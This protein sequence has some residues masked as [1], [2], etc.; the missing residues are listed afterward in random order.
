MRYERDNTRWNLS[1]FPMTL[2]RG[3]WSK[4]FILLSARV[5]ARSTWRSAGLNV[6]LPFH[7]RSIMPM[8]ASLFPICGNAGNG[9]HCGMIRDFRKFSPDPSRRLLTNDDPLLF[10]KVRLF[11]QK[12]LHISDD[13]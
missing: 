8:K 10:R 3:L 7:S 13:K 12:S 1:H 5:S 11:Q 6:S 2:L 4:T 9:T